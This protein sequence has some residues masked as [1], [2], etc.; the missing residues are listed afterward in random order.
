MT[1]PA[2]DSFA[3]SPRFYDYIERGARRSA[4]RI[5]PLVA[6]SLAPKSVLDVGCGRGL[7]LAAW[8]QLGVTDA[9]GLDGDYLERDRLAIPPAQFRSTDITQSFDLGQRWDLVQCLKVAEHIP[10]AASEV[11]VQN[12]ARHGDRI[13]FSAAVPGQ[14]G[15]NHINERSPEYWR[16]LFARQGYR[17]FDLVR[18]RVAPRCGD[19]PVVSFQRFAVRARACAVSAAGRGATRRT[20]GEPAGSPLR[21]LVVAA[22]LRRAASAARELDHHAGAPEKPRATEL[23]RDLPDGIADPTCSRQAFFVAIIPS[24][25][26]ASRLSA[27]RAR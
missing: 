10:P 20:Q 27:G 4:D 11:L 14:G 12:L 19:R 21:T 15:H 1:V 7:W 8:A 5:L 23:V 22:P 13:L 24:A 2:S 17:A 25:R 6:E 18:P 3:Y 26:S 16:E 9:L